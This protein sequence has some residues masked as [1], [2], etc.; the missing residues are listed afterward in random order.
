MQIQNI[1]I[2][3]R[4]IIPASSVIYMEA[5]ANYTQLHLID[6]QKLFV[7]TTLGVLEKRFLSSGFIRPHRSFVINPVFLQEVQYPILRLKNKQEIPLSRR[8]LKRLNN[9]L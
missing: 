8:R 5:V 7:A 9:L 2:G 1:H 6:N 3:G 4:M